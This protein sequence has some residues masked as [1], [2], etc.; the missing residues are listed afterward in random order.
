MV[1]NTAFAKAIAGNSD[2]GLAIGVTVLV[3]ASAVG[4]I[5]GGAFHPAVDLAPQ[6]EVLVAARA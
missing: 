4:G 5:S 2:Y 6:G 3:M 1:L